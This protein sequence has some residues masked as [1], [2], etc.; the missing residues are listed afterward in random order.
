MFMP[1]PIELIVV[2]LGTVISY[3]AQLN[4]NFNVDIVGDVPTGFH[5][6]AAPFKHLGEVVPDAVALA[7]VVFAV[8]ISMAKILAKKCDYEVDANQEL[9]AFGFCNIVSSFLAAPVSS[10]SMSRSL[11]Q[12]RG[13]GKTQVAGLVSCVLLLIVLLAIGPYFRTLPNC[14]LAA[15]IMEKMRGM[16][17]Q[18]RDLKILWNI[19]L[20]DFFVWIVSFVA[21]VLL[22]VDSGLGVAVGFAILTTVW[23]SQRPYMC[24][25]GRIPGTDIYLDAH[26]YAKAKEIPGIKIIRCEY[27]LLF[28]NAE[29]FQT[30]L[31][32]MTV[33]PRMIRIAQEERERR[34]G[35]SYS[36]QAYK[37]LPNGGF[38]L[39]I[40]NP[41]EAS[42]SPTESMV[43]VISPAE[44]LPDCDLHTIILDCSSW[45]FVDTVGIEALMSVITEYKKA[46]MR[47]YLA[48]CKDGIRETFEKAKFYT[49]VDRSDVFVSLH[50]AVQHARLDAEPSPQVITEASSI[51]TLEGLNSTNDTQ[52][53]ISGNSTR[54]NGYLRL[55]YSASQFS[56]DV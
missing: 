27:S 38:E 20:T 50:D 42:D 23:R 33:N 9:I 11:T 32:K 37:G 28:A 17:L 25:M 2:I 30:R 29:Y 12:E 3:L 14:V 54:C 41:G 1:V 40:P 21:T 34:L 47:F 43:S 22:D 56:Q 8:S 4:T 39:E 26:V 18:V 45:S 48:N 7:I 46:G 53:L 35:I 19:S 16:L 31:Y 55:N 36:T 5:R 49:V 13:G 52:Q 44:L 10:A 15:I 6:P 24:R 51:V